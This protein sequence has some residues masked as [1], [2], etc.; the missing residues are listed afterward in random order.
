[1]D[2][3]TGYDLY[4]NVMV[5]A[6]SMSVVAVYLERRGATFRLIEE[7]TAQYA[8]HYCARSLVSGEEFIPK[9]AFPI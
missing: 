5:E 6:V 9:L 3:K 1:M 7:V 4:E 2:S 8:A